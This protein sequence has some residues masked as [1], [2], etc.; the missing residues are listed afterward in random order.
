MHATEVL[1]TKLAQSALRDRQ[2]AS[3]DG[4]PSHLERIWRSPY[5]AKERRG[6]LFALWKETLT[7]DAE[8]VDAAKEA[9]GLIENFVRQQLPAGSDDSFTNEELERYNR[10][11]SIKFTPYR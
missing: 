9:R 7:S 8:L 10:G 11:S 2:R 3:L 1:R 5:P 6:L 4:L